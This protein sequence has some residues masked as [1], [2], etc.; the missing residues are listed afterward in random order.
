MSKL[1]TVFKNLKSKVPKINIGILEFTDDIRTGTY[2][3]IISRL[4]NLPKGSKEAELIK[5]TD[6]PAV[7]YAGVFPERKSGAITSNSGVVILDVDNVPKREERRIRE[8]LKLD[9]HTLAFWTSPS[10]HGIKIMVKMHAGKSATTYKSRYLDVLHYYSETHNIPV[11]KP[12][13]GSKWGLDTACSDIVRMCLYSWDEH[14]FVNEQS[15]VFEDFKKY[16][17]NEQK[18]RSIIEQVKLRGLDITPSY[19]EWFRI[20]CSLC[21]EFG[22]GG[23]GYFQ[24]LSCYYPNYTKEE[25]DSFYSSIVAQQKDGYAFPYCPRIRSVPFYCCCVKIASSRSCSGY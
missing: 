21:H 13:N 16:S 14:I 7:A 11:I 3:G 6:L 24:Q 4:R 2:K 9:P 12:S 23:R 15:A 1:M 5:S 18:V 8:S 20:C 10:G 17:A 19:D 22:E 25:C